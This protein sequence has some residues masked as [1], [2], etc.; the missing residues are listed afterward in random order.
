MNLRPLVLSFLQHRPNLAFAAPSPRRIRTHSLALLCFLLPLLFAGRQAWAANP[1]G[2]YQQTCQDVHTDG[3]TLVASCQDAQGRLA[4]SSALPNFNQCR[5]TI[6][7]INGHLRCDEGLLPPRDF[8][9]ARTCRDIYS[10][11]DAS[12][13]TLNA[14]CMDAQQQWAPPTS[15]QN[16]DYCTGDIHN[17]NGVLQCHKGNAPVGSY[18][19]T[20]QDIHAEGTTLS[21]SCLDVKGTLAAPSTLPNFN[22]CLDS[23]QNLDGQLRCDEGILPPLN[24]SYAKTCRSIYSSVDAS[25]PTL[26]A[27]CKD[28]AQAWAPT[29]L[30]NFDACVGDIDNENGV[31]HCN[32]GLKRS[33]E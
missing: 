5:D 9:Y 29:S 7:N 21:A 20:C 27:T 2:S 14:T 12:G 32:K 11:V 15:L 6:Q 24:D 18:E 33:G 31:L 4:A 26:H 3:T 17:E 13:H 22:Q 25:G 19:H 30:Q 1:P 8:S 23:I 10:S 28:A 16:F